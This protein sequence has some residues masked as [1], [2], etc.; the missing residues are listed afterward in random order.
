MIITNNIH[1]F[2][3]MVR[4]VLLSYSLIL[5]VKLNFEMVKSLKL[6]IL[7]GLNYNKLFRI[8]G[9]QLINKI[10]SSYKN[11][12]GSALGFD[13]SK[14]QIGSGTKLIDPARYI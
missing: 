6:E 5:I 13:S 7:W 14:F 3:Q 4:N 10:G 12:E 1:Y 9:A 8:G 2:M 11:D